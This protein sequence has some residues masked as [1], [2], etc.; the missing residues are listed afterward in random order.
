MLLRVV[1]HPTNP[2][3]NR[4]YEGD[5]EI[6]REEYEGK[7]PSRLDL[8]SPPGGQR[9]G[10]WPM[11]S[12]AMGVHPNQIAE[13]YQD[14]LRRGVPTDFHQDGRPIFTDQAHR[15][16]YAKAYGYRDRN[17]CYGDPA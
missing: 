16:A 6:T 10:C 3:K 8:N 4:Y 1:Y 13:A 2:E 11:L 15:K 9:P 5:K 17:A 12:D 14:S 7:F